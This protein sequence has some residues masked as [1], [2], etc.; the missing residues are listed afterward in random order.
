M[1]LREYLIIFLKRDRETQKCCG[2]LNKIHR[3]TIYYQNKRPKTN[4]TFERDKEESKG[5]LPLLYRFPTTL[6]T[7]KL[8]RVIFFFF[9]K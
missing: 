1:V 7:P 8:V 9:L 5:S 3:F 4:K 6:K 2:L